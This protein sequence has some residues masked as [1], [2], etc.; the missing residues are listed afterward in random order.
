ML[1]K[2][3]G[4]EHAPKQEVVVVVEVVMI[5]TDDSRTEFGFVPGW[6]QPL[7]LRDTRCS[8]VLLGW[9]P[10]PV[11]QGSCAFEEVAL[12]AETPVLRAQRWS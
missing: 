10:L 6:L 4:A 3:D 5:L 12:Q 9:M 1:P 2:P 8:C 7:C 11:L